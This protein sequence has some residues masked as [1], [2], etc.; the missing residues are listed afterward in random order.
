MAKTNSE[1]V[2]ALYQTFLNRLPNQ[3][4]IDYYAQR[5]DSGLLT[6]AGVANA[7]LHASDYD[8]SSEEIARLYLAAFNRIPDKDGLAFW[9][10]VHRNGATDAQIA[11]IFT[12]SPEFE[13]K[14]GP[15]VG[16][17]AFIELLY[18]NV[19][20]RASDASGKQYWTKLIDAGMARGD[21]LNSFAQSSEH[22][23]SSAT[24]VLAT[25]LY[26]AIADRM[27]TDAELSG[28]PA[29]PEQL[30]I[31]AAQA[32]GTAGGASI[33]Y[34]SGTFTESQANDG[35]ISNALTLTLSG[36]TFKGSAGA[37]LGKIT[38]VPTGLTAKLVKITD[39]SAT[40]T[41]TGNAKDH[42][43]AN[44]IANLTVTLDNGAFT[45]GQASLV[46]GAT[47]NDIKLSFLD[48]P[49]K[50]SS[51]VLSGSGALSSTLSIDLVTDKILV[52]S[53]AISL[54]EGSA[55]QIVDIDLSDIKPATTST[56][57]STSTSK[58]TVAI[59]IKGDDQAN[60]ITASAGYPTTIDGGKGDDK[61]NAGAA[62]DTI[63]FA[64]SSDANGADTITGFTIG[65]GGD[66]L[67]FSA[68]LNKTGTTHIA[69]ASEAATTARAWANGDV[70]V[71]QGNALTEAKLAALFGTGK[72]FAAPTSAGKA[73]LITADIVGDA[74]IWYVV[75]QTD[76]TA[77][78]SNEIK[79]VG[80]LKDINNLELLGFDTTNFA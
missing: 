9:L 45:S 6:R 29:D 27:P 61:I 24:K 1:M 37:S 70:L 48:L 41:L 10:A 32:A 52:G 71:I 33:T 49:L 55:S 54:L 34:S 36:D 65:K 62:K 58:T 46:S 11:D 12:R 39:T 28:A 19:L 76:T 16:T 56:S 31:K 35:S 69:T 38:N 43:S 50:E 75:N 68:F 79:L 15:S 67:N 80:T 20:G 57:T 3:N 40:L 8:S 64:A 60:T 72:A 30:S 51:H 44:N 78:T 5:L 74:S 17:D 23:N 47:K 21:V 53:S 63:V 22:K 18:S 13:T 73:V 4:E 2:S 26:S 42:G 25:L 77:I 66:V 7:F 59:T 14:Y